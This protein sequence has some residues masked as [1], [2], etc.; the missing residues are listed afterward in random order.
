ML[1][2][3]NHS[4]TLCTM[5]VILIEHET[6][7]LRP[8][9]QLNSPLKTC[10]QVLAAYRTGDLKV[11]MTFGSHVIYFQSCDI[12]I[13]SG[14]FASNLSKICSDYMQEISQ[15]LQD[16]RKMYK[17]GKILESLHQVLDVRYEKKTYNNLVLT[18]IY[19]FI[20]LFFKTISK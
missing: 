9:K 20:P 6:R 10:F 1:L 5:I 13:L 3:T 19:L 17:N 7:V 14:K 18:C 11:I 16:L 12:G 15:K 8:Q 4:W 2:C